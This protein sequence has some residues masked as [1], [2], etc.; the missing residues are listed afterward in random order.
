MYAEN[1]IN[2]LPAAITTDPSIG[3]SAPIIKA[4]IPMK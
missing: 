3:S 4:I 2:V 1:A